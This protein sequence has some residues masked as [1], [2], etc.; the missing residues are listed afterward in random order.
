MQGLS[1][2]SEMRKAAIQP[3][4]DRQQG[5]DVGVRIVSLRADA[6]TR[7][8]RMAFDESSDIKETSGC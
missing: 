8:V 3:F 2:W 6:R 7:H 5:E 1:K 4:L